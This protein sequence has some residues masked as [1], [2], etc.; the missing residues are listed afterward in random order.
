M[1]P[2]GLHQRTSGVADWAHG[3]ARG[4][5]YKGSDN[6]RHIYL[7]SGYDSEMLPHLAVGCQKFRMI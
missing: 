6:R 1:Q 4:T 7:S 2:R 3:T 5:T